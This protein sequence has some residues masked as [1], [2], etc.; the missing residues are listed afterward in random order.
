MRLIAGAPLSI[1]T[2]LTSLDP[3]ITVTFAN[4]IP[5][6]LS[7][8]DIKTIREAL[9]PLTLN[10]VGIAGLDGNVQIDVMAPVALTN[11]DAS[12]LEREISL[13]L[14]ISY[15]KV[16]IEAS[17]EAAGDANS[18][19]LPM[20]SCTT[21]FAVRNSS[22][23]RGLLTAGHCSNTQ[24]Y[25]IFGFPG[26]YAMT[27]RNE[28]RSASADLQWHTISGTVYARYYGPSTSSTVTVNSSTTQSQQGGDYVCSRGKTTGYR[29]GTVTS[30][31]F[32]P[33]WSGACPGTTCSASFVRVNANQDD[34][35]SGGP[36]AAGG[37]A[38]GIHKGGASYSVYSSGNYFGALGVAIVYG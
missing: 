29:C 30:I 18:G 19:G 33:T 4:E 25:S 31:S 7:A 28:L 14:G 34:G 9:S 11:D 6:A 12:E 8:Q 22:G 24:S 20:T 5:H 27:F 37:S 3:D 1:S 26:N 38:Y 35:D 17:T 36:W 16:N 10:G 2:T 23:T 13:L 15:E 32:A 21:G